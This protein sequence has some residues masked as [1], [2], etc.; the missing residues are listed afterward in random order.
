MKNRMRIEIF[1]CF[2]ATMKIVAS[3]ARDVVLRVNSPDKSVYTGAAATPLCTRRS[4]CSIASVLRDI[5]AD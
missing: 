4:R 2:S 1:Q 5:G 3:N